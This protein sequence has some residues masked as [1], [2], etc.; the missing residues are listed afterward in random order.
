MNLKLAVKDLDFF[1]SIRDNIKGT[2]EQL[3]ALDCIRKE[4]RKIHGEFQPGDVDI[5]FLNSPINHRMSMNGVD[6]VHTRATTVNALL[7][8]FDL[9]CCRV[10][11]N[12]RG[13]IWASAHCLDAVLTGTFY[14][15]KY[16]QNKEL[17]TNLINDHR[18]DDPLTVPEDFLF[19]RIMNRTD[20]YKSRGFECFFYETKTVLPWIKNRFHYGEW[21]NIPSKSN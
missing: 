15:P 18:G 20:K 10:A 4:Y 6:I 7:T 12:S 2:E 21:G 14:Q 9:P 11:I 5:F 16:L 17:F 19:N 3:Q 1:L 13:D 8:D